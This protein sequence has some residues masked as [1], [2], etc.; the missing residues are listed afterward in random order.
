MTDQNNHSRPAS[1]RRPNYFLILV[2]LVVFTV[3][4]VGASYLTGGIKLPVLLALA[5]AKASLVILFFMHAK[6]DSKTFS[7]WF[8]V[9]V[10]FIIPLLIILG[11]S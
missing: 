6:Y 10:A 7:A 3:I 8:L 9:G 1:A 2:L 4:E 5:V 11:F